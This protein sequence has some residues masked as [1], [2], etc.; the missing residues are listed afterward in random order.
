MNAPAV[1]DTHDDDATLASLC[2]VTGRDLMSSIHAAID[3]TAMGAASGVV[4]C[5][6]WRASS[7]E[8]DVGAVCSTA[9]SD[10]SNG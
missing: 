4:G 10:C 7:L 8:S 2:A 3:W 5:P 1:E 9:H 6:Q